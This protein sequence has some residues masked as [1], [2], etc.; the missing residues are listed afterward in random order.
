[1]LHRTDKCALV[2]TIQYYRSFSLN[3]T[4]QS[5]VAAMHPS[6]T[7]QPHYGDPAKGCLP[8]EIN[9]FVNGVPG[10]FPSVWGY[11]VAC[12]RVLF[13]CG[14]KEEKKQRKKRAAGVRTAQCAMLILVLA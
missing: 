12:V 8:D 14:G 2:S 1:M 5:A 11:K 4:E 7:A 9:V 10:M 3:A 6:S 13:V